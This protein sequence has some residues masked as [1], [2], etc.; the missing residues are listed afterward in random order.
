MIFIYPAFTN[1]HCAL[2]HHALRSTNT[3]TGRPQN[4]APSQLTGYNGIVVNA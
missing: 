3:Q 1:N 2:S 4:S